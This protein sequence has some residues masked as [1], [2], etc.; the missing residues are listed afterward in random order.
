M[1]PVSAWSPSCPVTHPLTL[2]C[3]LSR[4][5]ESQC[6]EGGVPCA[7]T[8]P[9]AAQVELRIF[10]GDYILLGGHEQSR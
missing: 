2:V 4:E 6:L 10:E 7:P 3:W 9:Q 8:L 1:G 5:N